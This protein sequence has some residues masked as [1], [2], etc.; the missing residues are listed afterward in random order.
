MGYTTHFDGAVEITPPLNGEEIEFLK[1]FSQSRRM[2][3]KKGPY[4]VDGSG[5]KG[6]SEDDDVIDYNQ[7]PEGQPS[8]WCQWVP[9]LDGKYIEWDGGEKFYEADKWMKYIIDHFLKPRAKAASELPFLQG[10]TITGEILAQG[11]DIDD[12]WKISV[13]NNE[14]KVYLG[15]VVYDVHPVE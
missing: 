9:S 5:Y 1:K 6:Q 3:R 2:K 13:L 8:L 11:E 12:R 15:S 7:P 10:H 14:V 4:F